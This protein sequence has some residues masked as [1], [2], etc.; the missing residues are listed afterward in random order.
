MSPDGT[1]LPIATMAEKV[2]RGELRAV[3]LVQ[4]SLKVMSGKQ[5]YDAI[6]TTL[7]ERALGRAAAIDAAAA[8]HEPVGRLA[9]VP[10]IAKDN[11]LVFGGETTAASNI[12]KGFVAPYQSTAIEKL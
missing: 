9:A 12:L 6:I 8:N 1:W 4:Q 2:G 11:Y 10:L 3:E 7:E 5:E